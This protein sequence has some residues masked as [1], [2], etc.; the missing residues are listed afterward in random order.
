MPEPI[1]EKLYEQVKRI[2]K[3]NLK[4]GRLRTLAG[5]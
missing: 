5:G 1:D 3:K 2:A 4:C